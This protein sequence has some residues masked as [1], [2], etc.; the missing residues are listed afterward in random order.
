MD[1]QEDKTTGSIQI[2]KVNSESANI[3]GEIWAKSFFASQSLGV[4]PWSTANTQT[5]SIQDLETLP[6]IDYELLLLGTGVFHKPLDAMATQFLLDLGVAYEIM[7][8]MPACRTFNVVSSEARR[9][10]LAV[11]F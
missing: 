11:L 5:I 9:T 1:I 10:L 6:I 4:H 3:N 8:T 7:A 2:A